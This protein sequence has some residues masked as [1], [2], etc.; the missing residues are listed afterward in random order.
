MMR[1]LVVKRLRVLFSVKS[2]G[3]ENYAM[4]TNAFSTIEE[5]CFI[6]KISLVG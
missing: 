2:E 6:N 4:K 3:Y 1:T 5:N